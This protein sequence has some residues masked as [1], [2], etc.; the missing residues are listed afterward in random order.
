VSNII[1]TDRTER[2]T[3]NIPIIYS[4]LPN[5]IYTGDEQEIILHICMQKGANNR[6]NVP[7]KRDINVKKKCW[8]VFYM[9]RTYGV[10]VLSDGVLGNFCT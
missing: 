4:S 10:R 5:Y 2:Q 1:L 6:I 8:L 9:G 3:K 7:N